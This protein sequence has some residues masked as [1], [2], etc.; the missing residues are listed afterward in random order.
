MLIL[1]I[2]LSGPTGCTRK[3]PPP[4]PPEDQ[5][6]KQLT[7]TARDAFDEG[8]YV[9]ASSLYQRA[10]ERAHIRDD[11]TAITDARYNL[12]VTLLRQE[13]FAGAAAQLRMA[14]S[15]FSRAKLEPAPEFGL[16]EA[17]ILVGGGKPDRARDV[18]EGILADGRSSP[19]VLG[20]AHYLRGRIAHELGDPAGIRAAINALG[21]P[22]DSRLSADIE[23]LKGRLAF[24]EQRWDA[25]A[26]AFDRAA[27]LQRLLLNYPAMTEAL[28]L[29]AR[30]SEHGRRPA[31]AASRYLQAGRSAAFRGDAD[32]ARVWLT[33][34]AELAEG[35]DDRSTARDARDL[36]EGLE[37]SP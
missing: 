11:F 28:A 30:A 13:D 8:N 14:K 23:E 33:R 25:A 37:D 26:A 29:G 35:A 24:L 2:C 3:P 10:L 34:A 16:L 1:T 9:A 20:R 22:D 27:N 21:H 5:V 12:A 31:L 32:R 7:R 36:L 4:P 15:E 19:E 6:L 18:T 17:A